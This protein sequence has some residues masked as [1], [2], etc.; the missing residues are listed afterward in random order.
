MSENQDPEEIVIEALEDVADVYGFRQS[1]ARIYGKL[2]FSKTAM[3]MD[4][5]SEETGFAKSTVSDAVNKLKDLYLAQSQ[6]RDGFG[7]TKFYT[8]E[9]D[10][11]KAMKKFMENQATEEIEIML[12]ALENANRH[13]E[14]GSVEERKI[15]N[16]Q[17]FYKKSKKLLGLFKKFPSGERFSKTLKALRSS[18]LGV[19][20]KD[21]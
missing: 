20:G 5:I 7:K 3:T 2:Y 4:E 12:E 16:M 18:I 6:K 14:P 15:E 17:D 9:E 21:S 1:Y 8:A 19:S 13:A 10:L 11:E